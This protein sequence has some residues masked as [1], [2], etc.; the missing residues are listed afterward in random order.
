LGYTSDL[1]EALEV[2]GRLGAGHGPGLAAA[3]T[4]VRSKQ[5]SAGRWELE[6]TPDNTWASFGQ[7][8]QP[9]KWVTVRAIQALNYWEDI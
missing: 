6:Y 5:D 7:L 8:G 1:L 9:N 3:V 2:L 4:I